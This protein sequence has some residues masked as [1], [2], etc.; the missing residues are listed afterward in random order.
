[1]P[2]MD[3]HK[4]LDLGELD[5][6]SIELPGTDGLL[7]AVSV[8]LGNTEIGASGSPSGKSWLV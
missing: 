1:M 8:G 3:V 7:D 5:V 4:E 6:V 2:E